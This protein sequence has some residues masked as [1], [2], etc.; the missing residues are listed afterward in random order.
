M[1]LGEEQIL[2]SAELELN[3]RNKLELFDLIK[4]GDSILMAGAGCSATIYPAWSRF[5]DY[6]TA[7]AKECDPKFLPWDVNKEDA[8]AFASRVKNCIGAEK[9]YFL[10]SRQYKPSLVKQNH[11]G[12]HEVLCSLP[13]RGITTTN[14]D[15][16]LEHALSRITKGSQVNY[17]ICIE[18]L[19]KAEIFEF[20]QS[21]NHGNLPKKV[22]HIHGIYNI[23]NSIILCDHEYEQKYGFSRRS[24]GSSGL[25]E[26]IN[27]ELT[28]EQF[29]S[30]LSD[31][32]MIWTP[33]R[34][35]LWSLFAT[36][37][38]I[39]IG[40]SMNDPY[41]NK[42]LEFVSSDLHTY[43]SE[44][45]YII[46]RITKEN[47]ERVIDFAEMLKQKY[48]MQTVFF[49]DDDEKKGLE[50][51]I[52]EI[53]NSINIVPED[54]NNK[55]RQIADTIVGDVDLTRRL[56]KISREKNEHED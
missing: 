53:N 11:E 22:F 49:E 6:L 26:G 45:H 55:H 7:E 38:L 48:G 16:V 29:Q 10:I 31:H 20:L 18:G 1:Q 27:G 47:K 33:L 37:R 51:F 39:F 15:V 43:Y 30:L 8:L 56:F 36:R 4:S 12:F 52:Q 19:E 24:I 14:Y 28:K 42:M 25:F 32:A 5:L 2:N 50:R 17:S 34:K 41:F 35:I 54:L 23:P 44:A 3:T 46:L 13:F 21:L 40:F 9:Y